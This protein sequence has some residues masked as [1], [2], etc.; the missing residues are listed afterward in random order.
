[1]ETNDI[2]SIVISSIL[3]PLLGVLIA[4]VSKWVD[5]QVQKAK[6]ERLQAALQSAR[7]ELEQ[8]VYKAIMTT[9]QTYVAALKADGDFTEEDQQ[10]AFKRSLELTK[11]IMSAAGLAVLEQA[12]V[13][14]DEAIRAEIESQLPI[15]DQGGGADG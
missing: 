11:Q 4:L 12:A 7:A 10:L 2:I 15:L 9:Q 1:M 13:A 6:N 3:V 5:E 14:I 8:A